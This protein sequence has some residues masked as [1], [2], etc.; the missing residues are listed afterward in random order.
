MAGYATYDKAVERFGRLMRAPVETRVRAPIDLARFTGAPNS[1]VYRAAAV[2]EAEGF[3]SRDAGGAYVRGAQSLRVGWSAHGLGCMA[4]LSPPVLAAARRMFERTFFVAGVSRRTMTIGQH[5]MSRGDSDYHLHERYD[6][7]EHP[8]WSGEQ[9]IRVDTL[10]VNSSGRR[11]FFWVAPLA[12]TPD[13]MACLGIV[14][15]RL[16]G[17]QTRD[18]EILREV[19]GAFAAHLEA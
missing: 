5:C 1:S 13:R 3:L 4:L 15:R 18:P 2:L 14:P 16:N 7:I 8:N 11:E 9:S 19:C 10:H 17:L 12:R 6:L